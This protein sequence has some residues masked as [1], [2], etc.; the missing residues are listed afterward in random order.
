[1]GEMQH[2]RFPEWNNSSKYLAGMKVKY[3][4]LY[5]IAKRDHEGSVPYDSAASYWERY[6][7]FDIHSILLEIPVGSIWIMESEDSDISV[8]S[9][10]YRT[11][12]V[13]EKAIGE[14]EINGLEY[15]PN[16]F[17]VIEKGSKL[18]KVK[19]LPAYS[20]YGSLPNASLG[21]EIGNS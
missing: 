11:L 15:V 17:D 6:Q 7:A 14:F 3:K 4:N 12:R 2:G 19:P 5:W 21:I 8:Q 9:Y 16:K 20:Y 10:L 13:S 1:M 18:E